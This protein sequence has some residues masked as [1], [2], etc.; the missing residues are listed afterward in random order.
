MK[1]FTLENNPKISTGFKTPDNYF[2]DVS[3]QI[4]LKINKEE[5]KAIS[6]Y[7]KRKKWM[8]AVAAIFLIGMLIPIYNYMQ[9]P[10]S[11][12]N[13]SIV[14]NYIVENITITDSDLAYLVDDNDIQKMNTELIIE[15]DVIENELSNNLK[16]EE[17]I[18]N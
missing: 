10:Y 6:L 4:L 1:T 3:S 13:Q 14:E 9:N 2:E 5:P 12:L 15:D 18:L 17:Y 16:I 11:D 8:Y 7:S